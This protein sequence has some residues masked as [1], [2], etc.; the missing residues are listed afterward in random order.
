MLIYD[1]EDQLRE[2]VWDFSRSSAL[3]T[4]S[5]TLGYTINQQSLISN[6]LLTQL[7]LKPSK[8]LC[9][10]V[11]TLLDDNAPFMFKQ[12]LVD[13]CLAIASE[14]RTLPWNPTLKSMYDSICTPLRHIFIQT[15]QVELSSR[16]EIPSIGSKK[17]NNSGDKR[18]QS[19]A[20]LVQSML[21]LFRMDPYCALMGNKTRI[22]ENTLL[23]TS[24]TNL[25]RHQDHRVRR[26]A[27]DCLTQLHNPSII[28]HWGPSETIMANFWKIS[29]Q[30]VL[31]IAR[32]ILDISRQTEPS[33]K[34]LLDL[35]ANILDARTTFL[36]DIS[37]MAITEELC[38][39]PERNQTMV[40][41]EIALLVLLCSP[42]PEI[43]SKAIRCLDYMCKESKIIDKDNLIIESSLKNSQSMIAFKYNSEIYEGLCSEEP[44]TKGSR[45]QLFVGKKAQQKRVRKYLR[46]ITVATVGSL[47][48]W[49]EVWKR[50]K[51]LTQIVIRYGTDSFRDLNDIVVS[52]TTSTSTKKIGGLVRHEKLRGPSAKSSTATVGAALP[53]P[54]PISRKEADDG[55]QTEWQNYTGFLAALGGS[56]LTAE[57]EEENIQDELK[58]SKSGDRIESPVKSAILVEKF[59]VEMVELL[60]SE[61]VVVRETVKDT[62][63]GDLSPSLYAI[64]FQQMESVMSKCLNTDGEILCS[65]TNTLFVEQSVLVIKM[66]LDRLTE[67][68]C[69]LSVDF[70]TLALHFANYINRLPRDNYTTMRIMIMMCHLVEVLMLKKDQVVIRD[71]VRVKNKLLEIIIEWTSAFNLFVASNSTLETNNLQNKEVQRDLD[72]ICLKAIVALLLKLPLQTA[73]QSREVDR[74]TSKNRLFQ[75]YFTF[76]TQLLDRCHRQEAEVS[77]NVNSPYASALTFKAN[78]PVKQADTY[79]GP[80][81]ESTVNAI[82]NLLSANVEVG[83]RSTLAM[84]YHED[85]RT[86]SAFIQVLSNILNQGA[87]FDTLAENIMLDR[88]DKLVELLVESDMEVALSLCDVCPTGDAAGVAEVLLE[89]FES[90]NKVLPLLKAVIEKEVRSAEQESTLFRGTNMAS[91]I[92]STFARNTCMDYVRTT[93]Q[94]ALESINALP[95]EELTWEMDPVKDASVEIIMKNKRN[96]CKVTEILLDAICKSASIAPR[97]FRQELAFLVN[98]VSK[99][100]SD[101]AKTQVG[102]FV[103]L[104]LFN[105]A[106]LTPENSGVS[107]QALPKSK[108]TKKILL[109]ATRLMQNL[110]NNVMFGAKEPHLISLNDFI[111]NN[112]YRVANFLR[113]IAAVPLEEV[114]ATPVVRLET[115]THMKLHRYMSENLDKISRDLS[116]RRSRA[117]NETQKILEMKRTMENFSNLLGQMGPP[118][119]AA[120][121]EVSMV[122]NYALV[123]GNTHYNEFMRRNKHRDLNSIRSLNVMYQGG[124]SR[125][126]NPVFYLIA[127]HIPSDNLDYELLVYYMLRVMEPSLNRP[128]ELV[129]DMTRFSE[130]CEIPIHWFN[131]FFQLIFSELNDFLVAFHVFNPNFYFQRYIRKLPRVITNRL[132]RRTKFS[133]SISEL[134][135][136]IAPFEIRLPKESYEIE[137]E[138]GMTIKN[139]F[140]VN[141]FKSMIP[142]QVKIGAEYFQVTTIREQEILWSLN[143]I[144]NNIYS[145]NDLVDIYLPP[146]TPN[147]KA[148]DEG[149]IHITVHRGKSTMS[150][151]VPNHEEVYKYLLSSKKNFE[152]NITNESHGIHPMD[153][154]GRMLNMALVNL[155]CEDPN[156]RLSAYNLLYSLCMSFRFS[157]ANQLMFAKD[158]CVPYNDTDFIVNISKAIATSEVHLTLEFL[159]ECVLGFNRSNAEPVR[160]LLTLEY[161]VPWLNNLALF[162]HGNNLKEI[163]KVKELIRSLITLTAEKPKLFE[164]IQRKVWKVLGEMYEIHNIMIDCLIQ[165]SVEHGV[166][167]PE[168]EVVANTIVTMSSNSIRGKIV[169]RT[170]RALESTAQNYCGT[171]V[172]HPVWGEIA[173]LIRC[174]TALSFFN[175]DPRKPYMADCFHIMALLVSTGPTFIRSS[176][177]GFVVNAIHTLVT[178]DFVMSSNRKRLKFLMDDVGDG[179]YRVHFGLN[180]SYANA[181][182]IT[183]ETLTDDVESV[184]LTS[185]ETIVQLLLDTINYAAPSTDIANA[186]RARWMSLATSMTF[187][188]N[189]ALQPRSFVILGCLAQDEIDDDLLFQIL[190]VLRNELSR[191][192]EKNS[193]LV[194]SILM[195]L[196]NIVHNLSSGSR[197]LKPMFWLAIAIVQM[198]HPAVFSHTVRFLNAVLRTMSAYNFFE[199]RSVQ[200]VLM[201]ARAPFASIL[202]NIDAAAGVSFDTQFSFAIAG[203]LLKGFRCSDAREDIYV[204]LTDFLETETKFDFTMNKV[205]SRCLGYFAGLLPFA[206][207]ND[208][209]H[210]LLNLAGGVDIDV[211]TLTVPSD[212][213]MAIWRM[214]DIPNNTTGILLSSLLVGMLSLAETESER[215]FLYGFLS[216]AAVSTPEVFALVYESLIPKMNSIVISS[217]NLLLIEAVKEILL[218]ACS[219]STIG[220]TERMHQQ[221]VY[222]EKIGFDAFGEVDFG[223]TK[224][225]VSVSARLTSELLYMI[226]E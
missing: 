160:Q 178:S 12:A 91:R 198:N 194:I 119:G 220:S 149:K 78:L 85:S 113:E 61:N 72:Q 89:A 122:R 183:D 210:E 24:M 16:S 193:E 75:K 176:I 195:C 146:A 41:L 110:A 226:C 69:L 180:K 93:L 208:A 134:S 29:C 188:F 190:V 26:A 55:K 211:D 94:P 14:E 125:S 59:V 112:L 203:T 64:L 73:E 219:E 137:R 8:T 126:G 158:M 215:L 76:F 181:F 53:F 32:Q 68:D 184:S 83:L 128:F 157:A 35:L 79:W 106:I 153:V 223:R 171:V 19:T 151:I 67:N 162:T 192:D 120:Q 45:K 212:V 167:S 4:L 129:F 204:C 74:A 145:M 108:N 186:W 87:Q 27:V 84:G 58:K 132:V 57:M 95:E 196:K 20:G 135:Q 144:L 81:K 42:T 56:R 80:L 38:D 22:E 130:D 121:A 92:L 109:Q 116:L 28:V 117:S 127:R 52:S 187:Q 90:R 173:C 102:G 202:S 161:I 152:T 5:S 177:H 105:P 163:H 107:K 82:S 6:Y 115:L 131:Q 209:L 98:A 33:M 96:V 166:G 10:L 169:T 18:L 221:K 133:T 207:K 165:Y 200:D 111:T 60:T 30:V 21:K 155:G 37:E 114:Q 104:R 124:V 217:N 156:L 185:L 139:A 34:I 62:L 7:R 63:G 2:K 179:K 36:T 54:A 150:L 71:D 199:N 206:A 13:A 189:P 9:T 17:A 140:I 175:N 86:R 44:A 216:K 70:G 49:E 225:E 25:M 159:N 172:K 43:C 213:Y 100:F 1:I 46:M 170:R 214:M 23:V 47:L 143:T 48:A 191:F 147:K 11:P 101:A 97:M 168:A 197:Y 15:V 65:S 201:E 182:T 174:M 123:S 50:W 77:Q 66:I 138:M 99:R 148:N 141:S 222:L 164:Q 39:A 40:T 88:Y 118:S 154:P 51:I 136:Y 224:T 218:T 142:V 103:F 3:D 31:S 205:E